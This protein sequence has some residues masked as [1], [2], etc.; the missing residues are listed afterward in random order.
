[1]VSE[2][3]V[4]RLIASGRVPD[5]LLRA[6]SRP[7]AARLRRE[8]RRGPDARQAF[9]EELRASPIAEQVEKANEQHYEVPAAFFQPRARPATEVQ[10]LPL[11][12]GGRD[13]CQAEEAMLALTCERAGVE[14]GMTVLDLGCGWGSL[15]SWLAERYPRARIVAVSNSHA[16]RETIESR[17]TRTSRWSPPT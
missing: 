7:C 16:Q 11:A 3:L 14:D 6:G 4:D 12:G 13:A 1:M 9:V 8:R 10:L 5:P 17:R 15:T 2:A